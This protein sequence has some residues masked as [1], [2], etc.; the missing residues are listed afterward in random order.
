MP[1]RRLPSHA[2]YRARLARAGTL[3]AAILVGSLAVGVAGFMATEGLDPVDAVLFS[4][5]LL[6]GMGPTAPLHTTAGKLFASVYA[7]F[8]GVV[9][10]TLA[11]IVL[12]PILHRFLHRFHLELDDE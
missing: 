11:A 4:S 3:A 9:F 8:S 10:L 5:M 1:R 6:T 12:S 2:A 7:L